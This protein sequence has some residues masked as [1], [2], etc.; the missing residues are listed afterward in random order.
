MEVY[1]TS[2]FHLCTQYAEGVIE[3]NP[4]KNPDIGIEIH[5][6]TEIVRLNY[7]K[8]TSKICKLIGTI[9]KDMETLTTD[10]S[11]QSLK[12]YFAGEMKLVLLLSL[13]KDIVEENY[14]SALENPNLDAELFN[15]VMIIISWLD[16]FR[17]KLSSNEAVFL[18]LEKRGVAA[19]L[20][21]KLLECIQ[22]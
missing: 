11:E 7:E 5:Q 8:L 19:D 9:L 18:N 12:L 15:C 22:N 16:K 17:N 14:N 2:I 3:D 21:L 20:T 13:V 6:F 4:T 1:L 10:P